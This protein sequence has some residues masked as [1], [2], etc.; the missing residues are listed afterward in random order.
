M[1][2]HMLVAH[3]CPEQGEHQCPFPS[4]GDHCPAGTTAQWSG[5]PRAAGQPAR[6]AEV[7]GQGLCCCMGQWL[8]AGHGWA[9]AHHHVT[10]ALVTRG[11]RWHLVWGRSGQGAPALLHHCPCV[12]RPESVL[13]PHGPCVLGHVQHWVHRATAQPRLGLEGKEGH[14]HGA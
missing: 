6:E 5:S 1:H 2:M 3:V 7:C 13:C 14:V 10:G 11:C 9:I 12:T 4:W 8:G